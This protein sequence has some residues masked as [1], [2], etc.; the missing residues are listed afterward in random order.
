MSTPDH[1]IELAAIRL[2]IDLLEQAV[3]QI[4][5]KDENRRYLLWFELGTAY[6]TYNR[7][8]ADIKAAKLQEVQNG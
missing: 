3:Q 6:M 5:P 4:N 7:I 1:N 8:I 2:R